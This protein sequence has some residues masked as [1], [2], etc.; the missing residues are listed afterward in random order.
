MRVP[1]GWLQEYCDPGLGVDELA[2]ALALSGTEVE[3]IASVGVPR[4]DGNRACS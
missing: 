2:T 3:R 4:V 1:V